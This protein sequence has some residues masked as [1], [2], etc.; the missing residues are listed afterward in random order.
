MA[1]ADRAVIVVGFEGVQLEDEFAF[2]DQAFIDG[3]SVI[4]L[5]TQETLVPTA[6]G[7]HIGDGYEGLGPH[8]NQIINCLTITG[9][10][11]RDSLGRESG[12]HQP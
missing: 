3:A 5:A 7:F 2:R 8:C 9:W 12:F 1:I 11:A 4:A 6:A 10:Q